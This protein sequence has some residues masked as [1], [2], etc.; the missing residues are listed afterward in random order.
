MATE[1]SRGAIRSK[2]EDANQNHE[3]VGGNVII[4]HSYEGKLRRK[5]ATLLIMP[6]AGEKGILSVQRSRDAQMAYPLDHR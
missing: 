6:Q 1:D 3:H 2:K 4:E 5:D